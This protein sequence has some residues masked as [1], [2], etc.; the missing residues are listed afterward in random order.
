MMQ[1]LVCRD[2]SLADEI[3]SEAFRQKLVIETS[4]A[5]DHVIK[6]LCPLTIS[7]EDL[8]RGLTIVSDSVD[9]VMKDR[10]KQQRRG[11]VSVV[12]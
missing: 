12:A 9:V 4:G 11:K 8:V 7:E 6:T 5:D 10:V 1:G 3:T 2:G